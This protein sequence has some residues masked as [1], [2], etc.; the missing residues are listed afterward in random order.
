MFDVNIILFEQNTMLSRRIC[1]I[2]NNCC[3]NLLV[4]DSEAKLFSYANNKKSNRIIIFDCDGDGDKSLITI[5]KISHTF[6]DIPLIVLSSDS[7][8]N[9]FIHVL[10]EGATDFVL[11][12]FDD[13]FLLDRVGNYL[14]VKNNLKTSNKI[15]INF[16]E[17][18]EGEVEKAQKG[19]YSL[20]I[21]FLTYVDKDG[22]PTP[23]NSEEVNNMFYG[24]FKNLFWRTDVFLKYE[25]K[26]FI[27]VFPFC[28]F[29]NS[30]LIHNKIQA[31]FKEMEAQKSYLSC[32]KIFSIFS[33]YPDD[34]HDW[35][36]LG[37]NLIKKAKTMID[38][39]I[40]LKFST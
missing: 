5:G 35:L 7:H 28:N 29:E 27:G 12:P 31:R 15:S 19:K 32:Y 25:T 13:N 23:D 14:T 39:T 36:A 8:R 26:Y 17:Y 33:T 38:D 24:E 10:L 4:T 18:L 20:C 34:A 6:T 11:K 3:N 16:S 1:N 9:F 2:L 30:K 40:D 37:E 21:M 22:K